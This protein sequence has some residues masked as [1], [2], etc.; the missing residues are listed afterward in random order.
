MKKILLLIIFS[1]CGC[2]SDCTVT[3]APYASV[4]HDSF[5]GYSEEIGIT[6]YMEFGPQEEEE[7]FDGVYEKE[8]LNARK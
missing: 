4:G 3:V 8:E 1:I 7:E 5:Y 2:S 6:V